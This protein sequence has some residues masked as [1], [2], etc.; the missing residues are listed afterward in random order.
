M[1]IPHYAALISLA[2]TCGGS[3]A[4][5][6]FDFDATSASGS[7]SG[8]FGNDDAAP[9]VSSGPTTAVYSFGFITGL[10]SGGVFDGL[11]LSITNAGVAVTDDQPG[12]GGLEDS[13]SFLDA[14]AAPTLSL[15]DFDGTALASTALPPIPT[16]EEFEIAS[17]LIKAT[18]VQGSAG[19]EA[20]VFFQIT[21]FRP[22]S[23]SPAPVP[24]PLPAAML[25]P[26]LA[27]LP[28][29]RKARRR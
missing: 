23:P 25:L 5:I 19:S 17:L 2:A 22:S 14:L 4:T 10:F 20:P 12:L 11:S 1:R 21:S 6:S 28:I 13:L 27:V 9:A 18:D 24:V 7:L 3:A 15:L 26:A 8:R 29:I 16:F